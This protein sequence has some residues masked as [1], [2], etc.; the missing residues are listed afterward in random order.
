[1]SLESMEGKKLFRVTR[2]RLAA[3]YALVMGA[4]MGASGLGVYHVFAQA[5]RESIDQG[6]ESIAD[7]LKNSIEPVLQQPKR[8]HQIAEQLSFD[9]CIEADC[10]TKAAVIK[11]QLAEA[12]GTVNYYTRLLDPSGKPVALAG[13]HLEELPI[14]LPVKHWRILKDQLGNDYR[15][16]S[17][18]LYSQNQLSGYIQVGR[19]LKDLDRHLTALKL[20][21]FLG[22]PII[23][24]VIAISSWWLAGLAIQ[25]VYR[26][27]QQME[28]F[29]ADAAHEFRTPLAA[30]RSTIDAAYRLHGAS[31]SEPAFQAF[32]GMLQVLKRQNTR[33]SQLVADLLLLTRLDQQ[34]TTGK[35]QSC[36]LNDLISD[37]IEELAFLA[38]EAQVLLIKQ[39]CVQDNLYI[40]GDE[41]QLYRLISNLIVN[42]IQATSTGGQ[43]IVSL[44]CNEWYALIKIKDTGIGIAP[45]HI[46]QIFNR[47]YRIDKDRSRTTGGSGLGLAIALAIAK[48][49]KGMIQVDSQLEVGSTFTVKLPLE[50]P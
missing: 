26:S 12:T 40:L 34:Q 24:V 22:C 36:C 5:Y 44:D 17:L 28:Q 18:P 3:W 42:A 19:S 25:P 20:T 38:V 31:E 48:A 29:T 45:E 46:S 41:E 9:L 33:L 30:M 4:I 50:K 10:F 47:F 35:Y 23:I 49:H 14:T 16:I 37:L 43:V 27:Y 11:R 32:H 15:Q 39:V 13:L 1:M 21:L 7:A 6:L 2:L 8:L